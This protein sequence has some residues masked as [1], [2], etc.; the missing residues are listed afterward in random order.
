M[1][2]GGRCVAEG[3]HQTQLQ[4]G[5]RDDAAMFPDGDKWLREHCGAKPT[6]PGGDSYKGRTKYYPLRKEDALGRT[7]SLIGMV[8]GPS[9]EE[10][11]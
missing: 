5:P 2:Y 6:V 7:G 10:G 1:L 8:K 3:K 11:P 4:K 9:E